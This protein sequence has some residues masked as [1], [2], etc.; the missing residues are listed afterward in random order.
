MSETGDTA[1]TPPTSD[2]EPPQSGGSSERQQSDSTQGVGESPIF[3]NRPGA[4]SNVLSR[5]NQRGNQ[6]RQRGTLDA[7][8]TDDGSRARDPLRE[9]Q[10]ERR[11]ALEP[12]FN[13]IL[14][15]GLVNSES[16][17][18][19][20]WEDAKDLPQWQPVDIERYT[21][22]IVAQLQAFLDSQ[23]DDILLE[24]DAQISIAAQARRVAARVRDVASDSVAKHLAK[25]AAS[26]RRVAERLAELLPAAP[27]QPETTGDPDR[28]MS[29]ASEVDVVV[30]PLDP[31]HLAKLPK[32]DLIR[33]IKNQKIYMEETL[34]ERDDTIEQ[35]EGEIEDC[36]ATERD[37]TRRVDRITTDAKK[38]KAFFEANLK[39]VADISYHRGRRD[40]L[41]DGSG[42]APPLTDEDEKNYEA[43][44]RQQ[45]NDALTPTTPSVQKGPSSLDTPPKDE[46]E[47]DRRQYYDDLQA[48]MAE[49]YEESAMSERYIAHIREGVHREALE[50]ALA[51]PAPLG[52]AA[53]RPDTSSSRRTSAT[54]SSGSSREQLQ[55]RLR[56]A[57][58]ECDALRAERD[59]YR[60]E[61]AI[62][63]VDEL[64]NLSPASRQRV[65]DISEKSFKLINRVIRLL[66][67][68][69]RQNST[70][71]GTMVHVARMDEAGDNEE[72]HEVQEALHRVVRLGAR[73]ARV[74]PDI[75]DQDF[76]EYGQ[77]EP[78][79][80]FQE[81][82]I[83]R[84]QAFLDTFNEQYGGLEALRE[85][86]RVW[87]AA[88][89]QDEQG[90]L[91]ESSQ[92][93]GNRRQSISSGSNNQGLLS[94][95]A[96]SLS[97]LLFG[98]GEQ[99]RP[100]DEGPLYTDPNWALLHPEGPCED[101]EPVGRF[102]INNDQGGRDAGVCTCGDGAMVEP[103]SAETT[104][105]S[106]SGVS[107]VSFADA[108]S[109]PSSAGTFSSPRSPKS[110]LR[111][112][113][114]RL[115]IEL[116]NAD[117]GS[118]VSTRPRTPHP[119]R[120]SSGR[121][122]TPGTRRASDG[123]SLSSGTPGRPRTP[124]RRHTVVNI[125]GLSLDQSPEARP[126]I[127]RRS[128]LS[129]AD[130]TS[131]SSSS[132]ITDPWQP[133]CRH[134]D[135]ESRVCKCSGGCED[136][137]CCEHWRPIIGC[138]CDGTCGNHQ[139][140]QHFD[141]EEETCMCFASCTEHTECCSCGVKIQ[142]DGTI[143]CN[144]DS[145]C[146]QHA[147]CDHY[148]TDS[149]TP[150]C[151]A[152]C[153]SLQTT[154]TC[155][156]PQVPGPIDTII[157]E[158][159]LLCERHP[160]CEH[161]TMVDGRIYCACGK[162]CNAHRCCE[163]YDMVSDRTCDCGRNCETHKSL[164]LLKQRRQRDTALTIAPW[165]ADENG[166]VR[167]GRLSIEVPRRRRRQGR[168][169]PG[170][171]LSGSTPTRRGALGYGCACRCRMGGRRNVLTAGNGQRFAFYICKKRI[172]QLEPAPSQ[173]SEHR[174]PIDPFVDTPESS[175]TGD[176]L[177][178]PATESTRH[179]ALSRASQATTA[180]Q[181]PSTATVGASSLER[182]PQDILLPPEHGIE[183]LSNVLP[184]DPRGRHSDRPPQGLRPMP[185]QTPTQRERRLPRSPRLDL[186]PEGKTAT[187]PP[188]DE[189]V[190]EEET[191]GIVD[192]PELVPQG[193][194]HQD[195]QRGEPQDEPRENEPRDAEAQ[196]VG[197]PPGN[198]GKQASGGRPPGRRPIVAPPGEAQGSP[199]RRPRRGGDDMSK[200][201]RPQTPEPGH[202]PLGPLQELW[203]TVKTV[204]CFLTWEQVYNAWKIGQ[205]LLGLAYCA[206][207]HTWDRY[208]KLRG[209][210][211]LH[212]WAPVLPIYQIRQLVLWL[213]IV[214]FSTTMIAL[215]EERR[216]WL[217]ANPRT[218]SYMRGLRYR[219]PYPS[220]SPFQVDY[221]LLEPAFDGLSVCVH[222][223][224][225][226]PG[227]ASLFGLDQNQ[228]DEAAGNATGLA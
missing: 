192:P 204:I 9:A 59:R 129:T 153:E 94:R 214:W 144:C 119:S 36:K 96:S 183:S 91:S 3:V 8:A 112:P 68:C 228:L 117:T 100:D 39:R 72:A 50:R 138:R 28:R 220:W 35:Y 165:K 67:R 77:F 152:G 140:C 182:S 70:F 89:P 176:I 203:S 136:H 75:Y 43:L 202:E 209:Q 167:Q 124:A 151:M 108:N 26:L 193:E 38:S 87:D 104:R 1:P 122:S 201:R 20:V 216:L 14:E 86:A 208:R 217:A 180:S 30:D 110:I 196:P 186:G 150:T 121:R 206:G 6:G 18:E 120:S 114:A 113:P 62:R 12:L 33:L 79:E 190:G 101:C 13:R 81:Q 69:G 175:S 147:V 145:T 177:T 164:G 161:W 37:L 99:N 107:R 11:A 58:E 5:F 139:C 29:A 178:P 54:T 115:D 137:W 126:P 148:T 125:P 41:I 181:A 188:Q 32:E 19:N 225:F 88:N 149:P 44:L 211:A 98:G 212:P 143:S 25:D 10:R 166:N 93:R 168:F 111:R 95:A 48:L 205:Y 51:G 156:H 52:E 90:Q 55:T 56:I 118:D 171:S 53:P 158:C 84:V 116:A 15:S 103:Q 61:D 185:P 160:C 34:A 133:C 127:R 22:E 169:S 223:A 184:A 131:N 189:G 105:S 130:G 135:E 92:V 197:A 146:H 27:P 172:L 226:R 210:P 16:W 23:E 218:A 4:R 215:Q 46:F 65:A 195:G 141:A 2:G 85:R 57:E 199:G 224:I 219:D 162:G 163:H 213:M 134:H 173:H 82:W 45:G 200:T 17:L 170:S 7:A 63:S 40:L 174:S 97:G 179:T 198:G 106:H 157:R 159:Q 24:P 222:R 154:G 221:S 47:D 109:P 102:P 42:P 207:R 142:D 227:L 64:D 78:I 132:T 21:N 155:D 123:V 31:A 128:T 49:L 83:P 71:A 187:E 194:Q 80:Q 73:I 76:G 66:S 191:Q 60:A 74:E